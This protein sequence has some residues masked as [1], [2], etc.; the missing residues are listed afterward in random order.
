MVSNSSFRSPRPTLRVAFGAALRAWARAF[1]GCAGLCLAGT[2]SNATT[3]SCC[4]MTRLVPTETPL[5]T[6]GAWGRGRGTPSQHEPPHLGAAKRQRRPTACFAFHV[7]S[8]PGIATTRQV[9][10][11]ARPERPASCLLSRQDDKA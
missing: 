3:W 5:P 9:A 7:G 1:T 8:L 4:R 10:R 11:G 2:L 6:R